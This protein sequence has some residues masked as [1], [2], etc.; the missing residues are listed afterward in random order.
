MKNFYLNVGDLLKYIKD[1]NIS[2]ETP[3]AYQ[4][5]EDRYFDGNDISGMSGSEANGAINGIFPPGSKSEGWYTIKIKGDT[6]YSAVHHNE[7]LDRG[8]LVN[9][10]KLDEDEV[11]RYYWHDD[12]KD[13]R[14]YYNLEDEKLYDEYV[15]VF[16][17]FYNEEKNVLCLTAHY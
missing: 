9:E 17:C 11:G 13:K 5:I 16:D 6:Y 14:E 10:G 1:N 3:I 7:Q 15:E 2:D 12:Y 8:K 4:R